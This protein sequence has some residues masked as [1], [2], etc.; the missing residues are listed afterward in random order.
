M[1]FI[2]FITLLTSLL[3]PCVE[4]RANIY[5]V[6]M[7]PWCRQYVHIEDYDFATVLHH[8]LGMWNK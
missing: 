4:R 6:Q 7:H 8:N 5:E 3:Q 1:L 2:D